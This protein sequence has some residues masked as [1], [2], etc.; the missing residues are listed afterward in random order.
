M[1]D[2]V[3][4]VEEGNGLALVRKGIQEIDGYQAP[5]DEQTQEAVDAWMDEHSG[6]Y[7][8]PDWNLT[9]KK[10]EKGTLGFVTP[11]MYG[12]VADGITD[13]T[14]AIQN[15]LDN[16]GGK[17]VYLEKG[18]TYAMEGESI[19]IPSNTVIQ[20]DGVI[21][22]TVAGNKSLR[23]YTPGVETP[24][25]TG[26]HD[27]LIFGDGIFDANGNNLDTD[28]PFRIYHCRNITIKGITIK[29]YYNYHAVEI[30]GSENVLIDC[31]K[32][33]GF[34][35]DSGNTSLGECIQIE[36]ITEGGTFNALPYDL[37]P[38]KNVTIRDCYFGPSSEGGKMCT[39]IGSH[40]AIGDSDTSMQSM[41]ENIVI[42]GCLIENTSWKNVNTG[43]PLASP[44]Y[45]AIGFTYNFR[46]LIIR[47]NLLVD[48]GVGIGVCLYSYN[49][50]CSIER[51]KIV[52]A[53]GS[54]I[55]VY[56]NNSAISIIDNEINSFGLYCAERQSQDMTVG[57]YIGSGNYEDLKIRGNFIKSKTR[58]AIL[59][60]H[61]PGVAFTDFGKIDVQDNLIDILGVLQ[62]AQRDTF[63]NNFRRYNRDNSVILYDSSSV[64]SG[65]IP[66]SIDLRLF[67]HIEI[68]FLIADVAYDVQL[69]T[70]DQIQKS[71]YTALRAFNLP[72]TGST[73]SC[74][75]Y[76]ANITIASDYMSIDVGNNIR[77]DVGNGV[78]Y[79]FKYDSSTPSNN[80]FLNI[81]KIRGFYGS[82]M[83][84]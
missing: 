27:V 77:F 20:W 41:H 74:S 68:T 2:K 6:S 10:L 12:A 26:I 44:Y 57:I 16:A 49:E 79:V 71:R 62:S 22:V 70:Q 84:V 29:N 28:T 72:N 11:E 1:S 8:V 56:Q 55:A 80:N 69:F 23:F 15:A 66:F 52:D 64:F 37:S 78:A 46:N 5:T 83:I 82:N 14:E 17:I 3:L 35:E 48:V 18:K 45:A 65:S 13:D 54:G 60:I 25:Y 73:A 63:Q 31:M 21:K 81:V 47:D 34:F 43:A 33:T 51:N 59:P 67:T 58:Y 24:G 30:A 42:E 38:C 40:D 7:I 36:R 9:Y 39:A 76:E 53:Y 61:F 75:Y 19:F 50:N 4:V 32:F